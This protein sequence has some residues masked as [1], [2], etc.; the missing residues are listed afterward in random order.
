MAREI[1][2]NANERDHD[3]DLTTTDDEVNTS[4]GNDMS[5]DNG[6]G[7]K[8]FCRELT[9]IL[10]V[11]VVL[12]VDEA[13]VCMHFWRQ[14]KC[15][16]DNDMCICNCDDSIENDKLE[17]YREYAVEKWYMVNDEILKQGRVSEIKL[18]VA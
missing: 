5:A 15:M 17:E 8:D 2:E 3:D 16:K 10:I 14:V 1:L 4:A 9:M 18:C 7:L 6:I 11:L 12:L 13:N